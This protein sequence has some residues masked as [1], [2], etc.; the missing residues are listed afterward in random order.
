[1]LLKLHLTSTYDA[2]FES[3]NMVARSGCERDEVHR[4]RRYES[5]KRKLRQSLQR[6]SDVL[7]SWPPVMVS[8]SFI[9]ATLTPSTF[10]RW[11]YCRGISSSLRAPNV[12]NFMADYGKWYQ[13]S[14]FG[15][16]C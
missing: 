16:L 11:K 2:C 3:Y 5:D 4:R 1:M 6:G 8:P 14:W 13:S 15:R 7:Q 9:T 10:Y 12:F